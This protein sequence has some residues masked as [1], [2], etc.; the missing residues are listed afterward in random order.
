M[1]PKTEM[2]EATGAKMKGEGSQRGE[3]PAL[4]L[5]ATEISTNLARSTRQP[6]KA[7]LYR[8]RNELIS[9]WLELSQLV[10]KTSSIS[11][12][13][14]RDEL[15]TEAT[16]ETKPRP[17]KTFP[18][19]ELIVVWEGFTQ[20]VKFHSQIAIVTFIHHSSS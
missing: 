12:K 11:P 13:I 2:T 16:I 6:T 8:R 7:V 14:R 1:A 18:S 4:G 5:V 19:L 15:V 3:D 20:L 9:I 17:Q 10:M